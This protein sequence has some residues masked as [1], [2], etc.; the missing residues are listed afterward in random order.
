[1][2]KGMPDYY[3]EDKAVQQRV[4]DVIRS[5]AARFCYNEVEAPAVEELDVLSAKSGDE[6]KEQ[7]FRLQKEGLALRFDL[8]VPLARMFIQ[9]QK[10]LPKPV[11]WY[12]LSRMWRYE[13][14][15]KGRLREFYQFSVEC[16]GSGSARADAEVIQLLIAVLKSVGLKNF[17][18]R[19]SNRNL[20]QGVLS[21]VTDKVEQA[22][23]VIDK[24]D[25]LTPDQFR[26]DLNAI[27]ADESKTKRIITLLSGSLQ[28]LKKAGL[29]TQAQLGIQELEELQNYLPKGNWQFDFFIARGLDYYTGTVFECF[30]SKKEFRAIAGGGRYDKLVSQLG[31]DDCAATGFGIGYATLKLALENEGV[32]PK[33]ELEPDYFIAVIGEE[34][35]V[36][37]KAQEIAEKYRKDCRVIL[38][39]MPRSLTNQLDYASKVK[40]KNVI[41]VGKKDLEN[42]AVTVRNMA[43]GEQK[44]IKLKDLL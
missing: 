11:K 23:R 6:V 5:V 2:V 19:I 16:Y 30:D 20:L 1:M 21:S 40:A 8:T 24:K 41:I 37:Q 28:D 10:E 15:Q 27:I 36:F 22:A 33:P 38:E 18:V 25:K 39:L 43:T 7:I 42:K 31:G 4:F 12:C 34:Q 13:A 44:E 9:K 26:N 14:P 35:E 29:N 3:P 32:L 17:S